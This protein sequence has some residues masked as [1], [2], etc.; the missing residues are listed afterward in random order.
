MTV[1]IAGPRRW[2]IA[3]LAMVVVAGCAGAASGPRWR[4]T[5]AEAPIGRTLRVD[6]VRREYSVLLPRERHGRPP[7]VVVLHLLGGSDDALAPTTPPARAAWA[8]G[9]IVA[10]PSGIGFSWNAGSCCGQARRRSV[11]D[12]G[13]LRA[14]VAD[15][16]RRDGADPGRVSAVG[17]SN[18]G[19]MALRAACE[20]M[21]LSNVVV[22]EG[23]L[24]VDS[25]RLHG[26]TDLLMIHQTG[27][28]IV[29]YG[30]AV[31][32][33]I[34]GLIGPLPPAPQSFDRWRRAAR[35][36]ESRQVT[37]GP[38][39]TL[40]SDCPRHTDARLLVMVGGRHQ[41]PRRP[42]DRVDADRLVL[43]TFGLGRTR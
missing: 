11:D 8:K 20:G 28:R 17:F 18:G 41:W 7:L 35:C 13:F 1:G 5:T 19:M 21:P 27:D 34:A 37:S 4:T 23:A 12:V 16:V 15:V 29:P 39:T 14:L 31:A 36:A 33:P 25:C 10:S 32:P 24:L 2:T 38:V 40:T 22:V 9:A 30:G 43:A 42:R 6:G 26:P 3:A